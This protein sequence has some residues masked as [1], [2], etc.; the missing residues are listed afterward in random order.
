MNC[1]NAWIRFIDHGISYI[2]LIIDNLFA[3]CLLQENVTEMLQSPGLQ[4]YET[5]K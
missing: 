1:I 3:C 4:K 5:Q 2:L